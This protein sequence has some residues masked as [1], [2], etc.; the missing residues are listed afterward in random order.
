MKK[1]FLAIICL[2]LWTSHVMAAPT[3]EEQMEKLTSE[4]LAHYDG[5]LPYIQINNDSTQANLNVKAMLADPIAK[6]YF[7]QMGKII[8]GERTG[9]TEMNT[10]I[11]DMELSEIPKETSSAMNAKRMVKRKAVI[12]PDVTY[13]LKVPYTYMS[14]DGENNPV[15]VSGVMYRP[16]PFQFNY[17]AKLGVW[18]LVTKIGAVGTLL[19]EGIKGAWNAIFGYTFDYGVLSCH[20]TV[21]TSAEA[22]SGSNPLDGSLNMFCSDYAL[23]VCPDYCGYGLTGYKQHPYLVQGVTAR[24]VV[25]GY[26][27][28]LDLVKEKKSSGASGSWELASDFYTD[29]IGYS[30]GG[31]VALATLRYLES[32][33]VGDSELK[34]INLRN[35]YCGDGPYSPIA[36]VNQYIEWSNMDEDKYRYMAY[37]CVLPLIVQAAKQAYDNDCMR[38]VQTESYFT[39]EFLATG[40]LDKLNSKQYPTYQLN[41][42]TERAGTRS[43]PDIFNNTMLQIDTVIDPNTGAIRLVNSLNSKSNEYKCLMRAMEYNDLTKGWT[44]HHPLVFLHYDGD[45]VVPYCNMEE[46]KKNLPR[47]P[48]YKMVFTDPFTVKDKMSILW[49]LADS[50]HLHLLDNPDHGSVGQFFFMAAAAGVYEDMLKE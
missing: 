41:D 30:Q 42:I 6:R 2:T 48:K 34:R 8:M 4:F 29:L 22:P 9:D 44:P 14:I 28:A 18:N 13:C 3:S 36:T 23:V 27:A 37:P 7:E 39:P 12:A 25:D 31:S 1:I 26:I 40:I 11:L 38:T 17:T 21:T 19:I 43:V 50:W 49:S 20:P 15:R 24:N 46:V 5:Q 10:E 35:V 32:G 45:L 16:S 33:Q 47:D